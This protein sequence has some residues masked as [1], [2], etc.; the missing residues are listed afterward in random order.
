LGGRQ[1]IFEVLVKRILLGLLV[2]ALVELALLVWT[3]RL[4]GTLF[5]IFAVLISM[6]AGGLVIR[7]CGLKTLA[8]FGETLRTGMPPAGRQS[9]GLAG[10][11]A[12]I[13]LI[14]PGFL[15]DLAAI[16]LLLPGARRMV[17]SILGSR[18]AAAGGV[19]THRQGPVIEGEAVEIHRAPTSAHQ[20]RQPSPWR[21]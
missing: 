9:T 16:L 19:R 20:V 6:I 18:V 14:L 21:Q 17:A 10:I 2:F 3:G 7:H 8:R 1:A 11:F 15:S 12:G 13:L 5:P 4:F